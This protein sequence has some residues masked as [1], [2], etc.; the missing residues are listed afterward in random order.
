MS[1]THITDI[2]YKYQNTIRNE[3]MDV[4]LRYKKGPPIIQVPI[5]YTLLTTAIAIK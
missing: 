3:T 2:L 1:I 5:L 4:N